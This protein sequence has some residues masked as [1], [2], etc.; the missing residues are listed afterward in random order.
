MC[1][2]V[3]G[4]PV[5]NVCLWLGWPRWCVPTLFTERRAGLRIDRSWF[6]AFVHTWSCGC[7][8]PSI[9]FPFGP[10][11][12]CAHNVH[13]CLLCT[14]VTIIA[15]SQ[16]VRLLFEVKREALFAR[17][18]VLFDTLQV[19]GLL[20]S[21]SSSDRS[22]FAVSVVPLYALTNLVGMSGFV[23]AG[24][25]AECCGRIYWSGLRCNHLVS[26]AV[27]TANR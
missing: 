14:F 27:P 8:H 7:H 22:W 23:C 21:L 10:T 15:A 18:R 9:R 6:T 4:P 13:T 12:A 19:V 17:L 11:G 20:L 1:G 2:W 26:L 5:C 24:R 25:R 16:T 3:C